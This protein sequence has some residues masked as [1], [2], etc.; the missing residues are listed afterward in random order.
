MSDAE[1]LQ[2]LY[3]LFFWEAL[4]PVF[5]MFGIMLVASIIVSLPMAWYLKH[6]GGR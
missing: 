6:R 4:V 3:D 1:K 5:S 2:G